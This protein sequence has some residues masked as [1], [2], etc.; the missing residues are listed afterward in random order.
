MRR[1]LLV[2]ATAFV[3]AIALLTGCSK[4]DDHSATHGAATSSSA[5]TQPHNQADVTFAQN[6][7]PHH[8]QAIQ[9]SDEILAKQGID[10]RVVTL[11]NQIKSAQGPEIQQMQ[12]WLGQW[13]AATS[14]MPGHDMGSM[15][16]MS[17]IMSE[18]D[19]TALQNAQGVEAS[20][21]F[22][23]QMIEHHKG[24]ITMAQ[25]EVKSGQYPAAV[26]MAKQIVTTQQQEIDQMQGMLSSL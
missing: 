20:K 18:Q 16:G 4:S 2:I 21:L 14:S 7:V 23:T 6:M 11:A 13:G 5:T 3:A 15:P 26:A 22:L 25:D 12:T 24:A 1:Q 19:M 17:G 9:M 8:Q 10:P